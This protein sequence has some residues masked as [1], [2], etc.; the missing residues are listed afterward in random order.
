MSSLRTEIVI[1]ASPEKIW[2]I[3]TDFENYEKWNPFI[4]HSSGQPKKGTRLVNTMKNGESNMTF[5]P[6]ITD[7][8]PHKRFEWLGSL[9]FRGLF[10]GRHFFELEEVGRGKT[11]LTQGEY[12]SGILNKMVLKRIGEQTRLGF[13]GMN[14]AI[15]KKAEEN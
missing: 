1:N 9:F 7:V 4:I 2:N 11:K 3:L 12:F 6:R 5:K 8:Q 14:E 10:D 13:I 15:K